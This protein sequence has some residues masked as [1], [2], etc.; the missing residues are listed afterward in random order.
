[1]V[2]LNPNSKW[3]FT[4]KAL[5]TFAPF[6]IFI[7]VY[8]ISGIGTWSPSYYDSY[9]SSL[10]GMFGQMILWA[11]I[12]IVFFATIAYIYGI[13]SYEYYRYGLTEEGFKKE[14]GIIIKK[15][16]TI[17]YSRIQNVDIY[18]NLIAR[19]LGLSE[20]RIQTAGYSAGNRT[21]EGVL[22]GVT[23]EEAEKIR[24]ELIKRVDDSKKQGL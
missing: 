2:K 16:T 3:L 24:E 7:A 18:R 9:N 13:L 4:W 21:S 19:Y 22:P 1:M 11:F 20:I 17:P 23:V 10:I 14:Y 12:S 6:S 8:F 15:Y 5:V